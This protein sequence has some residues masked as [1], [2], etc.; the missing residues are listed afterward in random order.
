MTRFILLSVSDGI[1][2]I[3]LNRPERLNAW[4]APMREEI[5]AALERFDVDSKV[6]ALIMTGA[7]ER[8]FCAG[9]DLEEAHDFDEARA[10]LWIKE[11]E[12]FYSALRNLSKPIVMALNGVAAG[13]AFQV[14]LLGDVRVGHPGVRM[15]QPEIDAGIAS[16]TGPWIMREMIGMSRTIELTL[17]ARLMDAEECRGIGLLHHVVPADQV[18]EK[19]RAIAKELGAK[20]PVAMRLNKQRFREM[21]EAGFRDTIEA[22][23][24]IHR[25]SYASGEP[26]RMM[27]EFFRKR[28]KT[29]GQ[30][31]K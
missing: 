10:E 30:P 20:P 29:V 7:G 28:G 9:Q 15:G 4:H 26:V 17:T 22:A 12:R 2:T 11:W 5:I 24:R 23:I 27:E 14:A 25:E 18:L 19:A 6:R 31:V 16:V 8:A 21:T 3:T 1:A 13:S